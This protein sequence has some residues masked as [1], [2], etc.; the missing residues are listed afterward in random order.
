MPNA[1]PTD[2]RDGAEATEQV[3]ADWLA[4]RESG[5]W[6][7]VQEQV[8]NAW[9]QADLRHRVAFLRL[10]AAWDDSGRLQA[11]G[12]GWRG[13]GPPPRGHWDAA[14][15]SRAELMLQAL[16]QRQRPSPQP[17]RRRWQV[18]ALAAALASVAVTSGVLWRDYTAVDVS[19][20]H[21]AMGEIR[22]VPLADGSSATLA[23]D[24][25][26]EVHLSRRERRIVL[27]QGEG[28]FDVAKDPNRP[29]AVEAGR[30]RVVAVGTHFAVRHDASALRV[31]VTEGTVRLESNTG[32][33]KAQ[34]SAL[35]PAGSLALVRADG[36]L[37][38]S[39][40]LDDASRLLG[41]RNGL[42]VFHDTP[43]ADAVAEF[44]RY[45]A[46]KLA[47]ADPEVGA[48]LI[49]GSFRWDNQPAFV[50]LL[51]AGFPV[52]VETTPDGIVLHAR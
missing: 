40:P 45:N 46:S 3:A 34:P 47:I 17:R 32:D 49:G 26:L 48:M 38:R 39:L 18:L 10:Q 13:D 15:N 37:V 2:P 25:R 43:L 41:W 4:R 23:S 20:F 44:N 27:A 7:P 42:L 21:T 14:P 9:L 35:L 51:E 29:F 31:V 22:T 50:R 12:A 5:D 52:R 28:F 19:R 6:Q 16:A 8:F 11:L 36:V 30:R 1:T 24:S 33:G